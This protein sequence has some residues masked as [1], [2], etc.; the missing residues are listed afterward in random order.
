MDL[1]LRRLTARVAAHMDA[2]AAA[3]RAGAT[4]GDLAE[5]FGAPSGEALRKA[6]SRARQ[7]IREGRLAP[8]ERLPLPPAP[9]PKPSA[10]APGIAAD[11]G[12]S[13]PPARQGFKRIKID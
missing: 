10:A 7:G 13:E 5:L 2:I 12:K 4:W 3:R 1:K 9:A 8:I 6:D 11:A